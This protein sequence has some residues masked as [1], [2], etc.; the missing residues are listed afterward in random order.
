MMLA[1]AG[2]TWSRS[3]YPFPGVFDIWYFSELVK[4]WAFC[5]SQDGS[6]AENN[7]RKCM[8]APPAAL[9]FPILQ[10]Q[11]CLTIG[12]ATG[13]I[14]NTINNCGEFSRAMANSAS[15]AWEA[16]I[17]S[18]TAQP[19]RLSGQEKVHL[20]NWWHKRSNVLPFNEKANRSLNFTWAVS[21]SL[22]F[23]HVKITNKAHF[24]LANAQFQPCPQ[25]TTIYTV[26]DIYCYD[27]TF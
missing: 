6:N 20:V 24:S 12:I 21:W 8:R 19:T 16:Q 3:L 23:V 18:P 9:A 7:Y 13:G 26:V 25:H 17:F 22:L 1:I 4:I 27:T 15:C 5:R 14:H 10:L 11:N 2:S